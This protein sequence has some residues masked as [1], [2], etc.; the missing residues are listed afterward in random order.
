MDSVEERRAKPL[1]TTSS[2]CVPRRRRTPRSSPHHLDA[3]S[4]GAGLHGAGRALGNR[5]LIG[6]AVEEDG[7]ALVEAH[8]GRDS[9]APKTQARPRAS[10]PRTQ[11]KAKASRRSRERKIDEKSIRTQT[12]ERPANA[13]GTTGA[14]KHA[15]ANLLAEPAPTA[16][17]NDLARYLDVLSGL[18]SRQ[19]SPRLTSSPLPSLEA[20]SSHPARWGCTAASP[21]SPS[22]VQ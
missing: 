21:S 13:F 14:F 18:A 8:T 2:E 16:D 19:M 9:D 20:S 12:L 7:P 22:N 4:R 11:T 17:R 5:R 6:A 15:Q 1:A 3:P 10:Q